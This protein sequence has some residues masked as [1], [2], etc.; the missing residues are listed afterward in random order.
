MARSRAV[1][2][3][4]RWVLAGL[5]FQAQQATSPTAVSL[6]KSRV[7]RHIWRKE[8]PMLSAQL[9]SS[10]AGCRNEAIGRSLEPLGR[11][12][13]TSSAPRLFFRTTAV[14]LAS[15][16]KSIRGSASQTCAARAF[17]NLGSHQPAGWYE[18]WDGAAHR[19]GSPGRSRPEGARAPSTA[20]YARSA[21]RTKIDAKSAAAG[22]RKVMLIARGIKPGAW[23]SRRYSRPARYRP[24]TSAER[25]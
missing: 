24:G 20:N 2:A 4:M 10:K 15:R 1:L 22:A 13:R 8:C 3:A 17:P 7:D 25:R 21:P 16:P 14:M 19:S 6:S 11:A 5:L 9:H 12:S 23:A 18:S